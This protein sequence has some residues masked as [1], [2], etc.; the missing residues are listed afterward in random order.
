MIYLNDTN[1]ILNN[2]LGGIALNLPEQI[3]YIYTV[4]EYKNYVAEH[5][6][7]LPSGDLNKI[8]AI[9]SK[10]LNNSYYNKSEVT[11]EV[12]FPE[13]ESIGMYGMQLAFGKTNVY[14]DVVFP[15]LTYIEDYGLYQTFNGSNITSASFPVLETCK[16]LVGLGLAF[17]DCKK[18]SSASF[19]S[20]KTISDGLSQTFAGCT[21]LKEVELPVLETIYSL[22]QT[23]SNCTNLETISFPSLVNI[24]SNSGLT[25][26][27]D[28]CENLKEIHFRKD[29]E[30]TVKELERYDIAFGSKNAT[31]Y[32]D[33]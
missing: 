24:K 7:T 31:I 3:E 25:L 5:N 19:P 21:N 32:L 4:E 9:K 1:V 11:G 15:K 18:L 33:L 6:Y 10:E 12:S 26:T 8:T 20:L 27:F 23:F 30:E 28:G 13:L 29:M 14:G 17:A 2:D 22:S 16:G